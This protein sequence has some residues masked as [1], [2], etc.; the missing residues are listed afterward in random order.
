MLQPLTANEGLICLIARDDH[1]QGTW[2]QKRD[3]WLPA[4][5]NA[6][7]F[8]Y[9]LREYGVRLNGYKAD[10]AWLAAEGLL[11]V[12]RTSLG[13]CRGGVPMLVY[14]I[15][16]E[17]R[18]R[19]RRFQLAESAPWPKG[20]ED[21]YQ[22]SSLET[23]EMELMLKVNSHAV[24]RRVLERGTHEMTPDEWEVI[25]T[26]ITATVRSRKWEGPR[27]WPT[28]ACAVDYLFA[29]RRG[30]TLTRRWLRS[31]GLMC[32]TFASCNRDKVSPYNRARQMINYMSWVE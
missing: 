2:D 13:N 22:L 12:T 8:R 18:K 23:G 28:W 21:M 27:R 3:L 30:S 1:E 24:V 17:G 14:T 10:L 32:R 11:E 7:L 9:A 19:L 31:S 15:T 6:G 4:N 26:W 5:T 29:G 25:A 16:K 20:G